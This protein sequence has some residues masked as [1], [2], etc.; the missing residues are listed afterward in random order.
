MPPRPRPRVDDPRDPSDV[1]YKYGRAPARRGMEPAPRPAHGRSRSLSSFG[2]A[3]LALAG[4]MAL[5]GL[6]AAELENTAQAVNWSTGGF[7]VGLVGVLLVAV[8]GV[9]SWR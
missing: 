8:A 6:A 3:V 4:V 2:F 9:M 7:V 5:V 1:K